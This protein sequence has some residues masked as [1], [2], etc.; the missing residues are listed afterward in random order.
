M[1]AFWHAVHDVCLLA[2][3]VG[4]LTRFPFMVNDRHFLIH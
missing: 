4:F 2:G 1:I 3:S